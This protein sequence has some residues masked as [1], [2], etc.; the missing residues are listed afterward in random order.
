LQVLELL[1]LQ[2]KEITLLVL[3]EKAGATFL[4]IKEDDGGGRG[5]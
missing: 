1:D 2:S 4:L 3:K 5:V